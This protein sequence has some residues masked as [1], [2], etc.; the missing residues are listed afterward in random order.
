MKTSKQRH[1]EANNDTK[2]QTNK[3]HKSKIKETKETDK[4]K[5][6]NDK[7]KKERK[8]KKVISIDVLIFINFIAAEVNF[9]RRKCFLWHFLKLS[10]FLTRKI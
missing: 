1:K 7:N 2:K 10:G 3:R 6:K 4:E 8:E 5:A 9:S